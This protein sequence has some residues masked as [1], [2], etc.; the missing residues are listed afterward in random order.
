MFHNNLLTV[1]ATLAV[2]LSLMAQDYTLSISQ[3]TG[4]PAIIKTANI[5][6]IAFTPSSAD[7]TEDGNYTFNLRFKNGETVSFLLSDQPVISFLNDQCV[8]ECNDF[9]NAFPINDIDFGSFEVHS[10]VGA[11]VEDLMT[12]D[13]TN[14]ASAVIRGLKSCGNAILYSIDGT[15]LQTAVAGADGCVSLDISQIARGKAYIISVNATTNF[16][17]YKK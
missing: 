12:L 9:T 1:F 10:G 14:P 15:I 6:N 5:E 4:E 7:R 8:I 13:L 2:H 17:L 16:K 3:K 11:A